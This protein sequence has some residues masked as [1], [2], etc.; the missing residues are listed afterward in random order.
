MIIAIS[1][2]ESNKK[3]IRGKRNQKQRE[4]W[5]LDQT[6][7]G[8]RV[9]WVLSN[10]QIAFAA[11]NSNLKDRFNHL[12]QFG[13]HRSKIL[14]HEQNWKEETARIWV[15]YDKVYYLGPEFE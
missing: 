10:R 7:D 6:K 12:Y 11:S 14:M 3:S 5:E 15:D 9:L 1:S 2:K 4:L 13:V 8:D